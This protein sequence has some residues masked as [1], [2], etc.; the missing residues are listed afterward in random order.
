MFWAQRWLA[1]AEEP[2]KELTAQQQ[3]GSA[4]SPKAGCSQDLWTVGLLGFLAQLARAWLLRALVRASARCKEAPVPAKWQSVA[5]AS[6]QLL[7]VSVEPCN[8][9]PREGGSAD[10]RAAVQSGRLSGQASAEC[11]SLLTFLS[12]LGLAAWVSQHLPQMGLAA[13]GK[14][15]ARLELLLVTSA[16]R[17]DDGRAPPPRTVTATLSASILVRACVM[18]GAVSCAVA[19]PMA[20]AVNLQSVHS[21]RRPAWII[22]E[23]R[24]TPCW[25][26]WEPPQWPA[27]HLGPAKGVG[28]RQ[29]LVM[30]S[31]WKVW[32][33]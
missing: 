27:Q 29:R 25:L 14:K 6:V 28:G 1:A 20:E 24:E 30:Y 11:C 13:P 26:R 8:S 18:G 16:L 22:L 5:S 7:Q 4:A 33:R 21:R 3:A 31:F 15:L 9:S 19:V 17:P 12:E 32:R 10:A 23:K 2:L